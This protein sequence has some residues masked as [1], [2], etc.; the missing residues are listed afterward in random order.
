MSHQKIVEEAEYSRK[1]RNKNLVANLP[2][3]RRPFIVQ[4]TMKH[5]SS[6]RRL[7]VKCLK[8]DRNARYLGYSLRLRGHGPALEK[9]FTKQLVVVVGSEHKSVPDNQGSM[10]QERSEFET[11]LGRLRHVIAKQRAM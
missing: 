1:T 3:T 8:Q 7:Q 2:F 4:T 9:P 10:I 5:S 11:G 6:R